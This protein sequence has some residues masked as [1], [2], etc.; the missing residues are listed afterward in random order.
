MTFAH[1]TQV[2]SDRTFW[3][4]RAGRFLLR[5][6]ADPSSGDRTTPNRSDQTLGSSTGNTM[7]ITT[8]H[9]DR[10]TAKVVLHR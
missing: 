5:Q 6:D 4:A 9:L 3:E 7:Q 1:L 8:L 10:A 2:L